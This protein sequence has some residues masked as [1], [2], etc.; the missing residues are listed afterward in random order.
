M[1]R[2]PAREP[3]KPW[4]DPT[5]WRDELDDLRRTLAEAGR[6]GPLRDEVAAL[7]HEARRP[8]RVVVAGYA[9][10]YTDGWRDAMNQENTEVTE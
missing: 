3:A 5:D 4:T 6:T 7:L 10:G 2:H 1:T 8:R 9:N